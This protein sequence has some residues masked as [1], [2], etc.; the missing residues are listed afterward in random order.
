MPVTGVQTCA[1]PIYPRVGFQPL[2]AEARRR[3]QT[4]GP[5]VVLEQQR[6]RTARDVERVLV[7]VR[8]QVDGRSAVGQEGGERPL[9][10]A[11]A[12][13]G[14]TGV[15]TRQSPGSRISRH[16]M[17]AGMGDSTASAAMRA[18]SHEV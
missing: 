4:A 16:R 18:N 5:R 15:W 9:G 3:L 13:G 12:A 17:S 1:L 8:Q 14:R 7:Q 10:R 6:A 2:E 11:S